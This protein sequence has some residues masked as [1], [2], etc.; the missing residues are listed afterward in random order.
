[1]FFVE[2]NALAPYT[3]TVGALPSILA[4]TMVFP[5]GSI[6]DEADMVAAGKIVG[7]ESTLVRGLEAIGYHIT[8]IESGW[9]LSRCGPAVDTCIGSAALDEMGSALV[10]ASILPHVMGIDRHV[11]SVVGTERTFGE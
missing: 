11:S 4:G 8:M 1:G 3:R 7:G 5:A 6:Q 10:S 9:H 2:G